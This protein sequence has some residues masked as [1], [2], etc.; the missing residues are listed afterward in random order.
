MGRILVI[1]KNELDSSSFLKPHG[2]FAATSKTC[3][4]VSRYYSLCLNFA[5]HLYIHDHIVLSKGAKIDDV[6]NAIQ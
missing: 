1:F 2:C 6:R 3:S 4:I 5:L